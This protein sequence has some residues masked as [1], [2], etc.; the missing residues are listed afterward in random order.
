MTGAGA[1]RA[2]RLA[3]VDGFPLALECKRDSS[4]A[5]FSS[6]P[7]HGVRK[8]NGII[9]AWSKCSTQRLGAGFQ[10]EVVIKTL[11]SLYTFFSLLCDV[12]ISIISGRYENSSQVSQAII[13]QVYRNAQ[14]PQFQAISSYKYQPHTG[15]SL[16]AAAK[17]HVNHFNTPPHPI[18]STRYMAKSES[19]SCTIISL[20]SS[21]WA[22][23]RHPCRGISPR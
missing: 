2:L 4:H 23:H 9:S 22:T 11:T 5:G 10:L 16:E 6:C 12:K 14:T 20:V 8:E 3:T 13:P 7:S 19:Q 21:R 18:K 15:H 17:L 1:A